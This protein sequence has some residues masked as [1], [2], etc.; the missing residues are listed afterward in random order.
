VSRSAESGRRTVADA[1]GEQKRK[2]MSVGN[3]PAAVATQLQKM[4]RA[5]RSEAPWTSSLTCPAASK[6]VRMP[7]VKT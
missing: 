6:P 4:P 2:T 5:D 1:P 3:A 7:E